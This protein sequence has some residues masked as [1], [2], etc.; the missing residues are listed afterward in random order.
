MR[1]CSSLFLQGHSHCLYD[2]D[3]K[4]PYNITSTQ[5]LW[6]CLS[7]LRPESLWVYRWQEAP[8]KR[9]PGGGLPLHLTLTLCRHETTVAT[10]TAR[11]PT[12]W[13][14]TN[15][16]S[17]TLA[18]VV[19]FFSIISPQ[20]VLIIWIKYVGLT[21]FK[22]W[23]SRGTCVYK[24]PS[25]LWRV[26]LEAKAKSVQNRAKIKANLS[27]LTSFSP[28]PRMIPDLCAQTGIE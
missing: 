8:A 18:F 28:L 27:T 2:K 4:L 12:Y 22:F 17:R 7:F 19:L 20:A 16:F 24:Y 11:Q 9:A 3:P 25:I 14:L 5:R 13:C 1:V 10:P 23:V 26:D 21:I 15:I 6:V